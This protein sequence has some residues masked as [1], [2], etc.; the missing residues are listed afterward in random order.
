MTELIEPTSQRRIGVMLPRDIAP[1]DFIQFARA[2]DDAG[3]DDLWVVED[4]FYRG[5]FSQAAVALAAT[6]RIQVGI[7]ILP[8]AVRNVSFTAI[9]SATLAELFPGRVSI[10]IGHGMPVWMRQVGAWPASIL[11][12]LAEHL[13]VTRA[14]LRGGSV[15]VSGHYVSADDVE[16]NARLERIPPVLAGVRGVKSLAVSGRHADGTIL[17]EP[18]TPQYLAAALAAI[19]VGR[20]APDGRGFVELENLPVEHQVVAYN[21]AAVRDDAGAARLLARPALE[22]IGEPDWLPHILPL[23]FADEFIA[24]RAASASRA[25]FAAAMPDEWIDQLAIVGTP[26]SARRR[27]DELHEAG[28]TSVVLIPAGG[29]PLVEL[30]SLARLL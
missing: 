4:C 16:L 18:V 5:G 21:V 29:D 12:L 9:E 1:R 20:D 25:E 2:A 6:T 24:L 13:D 15:M 26:E 8:A 30:A 27:V 23:P 19:G 22:W 17:A 28:A 10:G 14:L 7:G 3:F 11:N